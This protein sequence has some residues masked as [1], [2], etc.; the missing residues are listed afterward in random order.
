MREP[1]LSK[2]IL[3]PI[4]LY[5][6]FPIVEIS[7]SN[8]VEISLDLGNIISFWGFFQV[9]S[10]VTNIITLIMASVR[11]LRKIC[12]GSRLGAFFIY[13]VI[14]C[15]SSIVFLIFNIQDEGKYL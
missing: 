14:W 6:V 7:I 10:R 8:Y 15:F 12:F 13:V 2:I 5:S 3:N 11:E 4:N 1:N 9:E